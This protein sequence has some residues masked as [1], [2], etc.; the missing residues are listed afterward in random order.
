MSVIARCTIRYGIGDEPVHTFKKAFLC[1]EAVSED[2]FGYNGI[3]YTSGGDGTG[4]IRTIR[5]FANTY[6]FALNKVCRI[7]TV[8]YSVYADI[9]NTD[10]NPNEPQ[11]TREYELGPWTVTNNGDNWGPRGSIFI[12]APQSIPATGHKGWMRWYCVSKELNDL[13]KQFAASEISTGFA[14]HLASLRNFGLQTELANKLAG[15]VVPTKVLSILPGYTPQ[16]GPGG[17][18]HMGIING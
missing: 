3:D 12:A 1:N 17:N 10:F 14:G 15:Y 8:L 7:G 5:D 11:L 6:L 2:I 9:I 16:N 13:P 4:P 18:M